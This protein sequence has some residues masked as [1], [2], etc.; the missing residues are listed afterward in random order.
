MGLPTWQ[1]ECS[2]VGFKD[3]DGFGVKGTVNEGESDWVVLG[4]KTDGQSERTI[5]TLEDMLC[6]C[7][8]DFRG[9]WDVHLPFEVGGMSLIGH[10]LVQE[11]TEK[12]SQIKD[13]LKAA[14]DL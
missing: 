5:Q 1:L 6:A 14:R 9:S 7:V 3:G 11:T 10:E 13:G 2:E 8:L 12:I 4:G